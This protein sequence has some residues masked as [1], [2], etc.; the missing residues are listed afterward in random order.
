[1]GWGIRK[2]AIQRALN[3]PTPN[4]IPRSGE[5]GEKVDGYVLYLEEDDGALKVLADEDEGFGVRARALNPDNDTYE[6]PVS[7]PYQNL[8]QFTLEIQH[9]YGLWEFIYRSPWR[10]LVRDSSRVP[11][12]ALL[13]DRVRQTLFN[14]KQLLRKDRID[15]LKDAIEKTIDD[16]AYT[17][18]AMSLMTDLYTSRWVGHPAKNMVRSHYNL[19]LDSLAD[20]G[21][22]KKDGPAYKVQPKA[23]ETVSKYEEEDRRHRDNRIQNWTLVVLTFVLAV[24]GVLQVYAVYPDL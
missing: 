3:K 1:M 14:R 24:V 9:F 10:F 5:A 2:R 22:L 13:W 18:S 12:L 4:P 15:V 6:V 23:M 17:A 19:V 8:S 21:D 16:P 7:I 11:L 20:S